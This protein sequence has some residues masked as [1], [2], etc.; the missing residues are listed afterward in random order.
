MRRLLSFILVSAL[1]VTNLCFVANAE[2]PVSD[3]TNIA[4]GKTATSDMADSANNRR[5]ADL[6]DGI[7][8]V[9]TAGAGAW[10]VHQD[11][12]DTKENYIEIDLGA[13]YNVSSATI[14]SGF[15]DSETAGGHK[16]THYTIMYH[17]GTGYMPIPG[18]VVEGADHGIYEIEFTSSVVTDKIK[19][20]ENMTSHY[21]IR[22]IEIYGTAAGTPDIEPD[23][24]LP[25][26]TNIALNKDVTA[27]IADGVGDSNSAAAN[28]TDGINDTMSNKWFVHQNYSAQEQYFEVNFGDNYTINGMVM[29]SGYNDEENTTD[30]LIDYTVM[31]FNEGEYTAIPGGTVSSAVNGKNIVLFTNAVTTNKI[32]VVCQPQNTGY[33]V[34]ELE[35]YGTYHS[36]YIEPITGSNVSLN[37]KVTASIADGVGDSNSSAAAITD[38]INNTM[39]NKWYAHANYI[40]DGAYFEIDLVNEYTITNAIMYSGYTDAENT[41]D[42]LK[43]FTVFYLN[44]DG[45]YIEAEGGKASNIGNGKH[46]LTFTTPFTTTKVKVVCSAQT[47]G[48]RIREFELFGTIVNKPPQVVFDVKDGE[49]TLLENTLLT[50]KV[51]ITSISSTI[52]DVKLYFDGNLTDVTPTIEGDVYTFTLPANLVVSGSHVIKVTADDIVGDETEE[53]ATFVVV[54]TEQLIEKLN[55]ADRSN[56]ES[57]LYLA[58]KL[59]SIDISE[60]TGL[61]DESKKLD[62]LQE[63]FENKGF[64]AINIET[65]VS[66]AVEKV[67]KP[68]VNIGGGN[69]GGGN[70]GGGG[71]GSSSSGSSKGTVINPIPTEV[72][73]YSPPSYV[74]VTLFNDLEA[75]SWAEDAIIGLAE[76]GIVNGVGDSRFAPLDNVTRGQFLKMLIGALSKDKNVEES[77]ELPFEDVSEDNI[78]YDYILAAYKAGIVNGK[79]ENYFGC[80]D[81]MTREEFATVV[82]RAMKYFGID[83]DNETTDDG[84][85]F[86]DEAEFEDYSKEAIESLYQKGLIKGIGDGKFGAKGY[87]NRAMAAQILYNIM[88]ANDSLK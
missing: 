58:S 33:R 19:I 3:I 18:G 13:S 16:L 1:L 6:T 34:R 82:F 71:R 27:S 46:T 36:E 49:D 11:Y 31:Y 35:V 53:S 59:L 24:Q 10:Y 47:N 23:E 39:S 15:F 84:S 32:K 2:N 40:T 54:T 69:G 38:G 41:T 88:T 77:N 48:F 28:I 30:L 85:S 20:V 56:F 5:A 64:T 50:V 14:Y 55:N 70:G 43:E 86:E 67:T 75:A 57:E 42:L 52:N 74:K 63:L 87:T 76:K 44:D 60:L 12:T 45:D 80:D 78:F 65:K 66:H 61:K 83:V 25:A 62:V 7:K 9:H 21:R 8:D 4:L 73:I 51:E 26:G 72:D 37:K 29:Y 79:T 81:F 68:T 22:E 17:D